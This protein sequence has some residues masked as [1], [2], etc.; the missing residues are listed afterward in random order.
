[1]EDPTHVVPQR[2][3]RALLPSLPPA[4]LLI[5]PAPPLGVSLAHLDVQWAADRST[6][7]ALA[8]AGQVGGHE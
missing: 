7:Y 3:P 6:V 4:A 2:R 8:G 5:T 1:M